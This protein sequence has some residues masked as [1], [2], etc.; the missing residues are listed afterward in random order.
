ML[1][2]SI[3][4]VN[5]SCF[6]NYW[7]EK[8]P[9]N[10]NL[11][12][13]LSSTK[14]QE[15]VELIRAI[16]DKKELGK[17]KA[18]LPAI[19][20]SGL[21]KTRESKIPLNEKLIKHSGLIQI[22]IDL[23]GRNKLISNWDD[24]KIELSK[25]PNIA[26]LGKSVSGKGYWG[27]I[28]IPPDPED[29]KYYFEALKEVFINTWGIELDDRPKNVASLR[30]YSFDDQAY[31]N[32][33]A[34]PFLEKKK[35]QIPINKK[36]Y[37]P[38]VWHSKLTDWIIDRIESSNDGERHIQR[39]NFARLAGGYV[40]AGIL[41]YGIEDLMINSYLAQFGN[42]DSEFTKK[43]EIKAIKEGFA[44]GLVSP[45]FKFPAT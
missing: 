9:K 15:K 8:N 39:F 11:L 27:L 45:I 22:D 41:E 20:P 38:K 28:P 31:F 13:W 6:Q 23:A 12:T 1:K 35:P 43:K 34:S 30:G 32:H 4:N 42:S 25:I 16:E 26:Y 21:F 3:L 19:T 2:E 36:A 5:V 40:A 37:T 10:V 29:H 44:L 33:H 17:I 18:S 7:E 14:Y 24:L